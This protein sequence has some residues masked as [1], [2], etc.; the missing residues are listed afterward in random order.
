MTL[1]RRLLWML[2]IPLFLSSCEDKMSEHYD[3]KPE[4]FE[5]SIWEVLEKDGNYSSFLNAVKRV[6]YE[7]ML[8]GKALLTVMAP[9]DKAFEAYL[10]KHGA[11]SVNDMDVEEL[12]KMVTFHLLYY[13]YEK[14]DLENFRIN[15]DLESEDQ[16]VANR[17]L[18]Y[19]FRTKSADAPTTEYDPIT[20]KKVTVYHFERFMP[21][22]SHYF[23]Q[24]RALDAK[25]SY[26]YFY[27]NSTWTGDDGFNV[28]DATVTQYEVEA[29]NGYIYKVDRVIEPLETIYTEMKNDKNYSQFVSLY[30]RFR[31]YTYDATIS[32]DYAASAGVDSLFLTSYG[33]LANLAQEWST[34]SYMQLSLL[35][36]NGYSLFAPSNTALDAFFKSF[37]GG[38]GYES[39]SDIDPLI[40]RYFLQSCIYRNQPV[41]PQDIT[42]GKLVDDFGYGVNFD[43]YNVKNRKVC[44]NG[45][46]YGLDQIT[47]PPLFTTVTGP[48]FAQKNLRAFAYAITGSGLSTSLMSKDVKYLFL[49]ANNDQMLADNMQVIEYAKSDP[50]LCTNET[51]D[52]SWGAV[53]SETKQNLANIHVASGESLNASGTQVVATQ[54]AFNYWFVDNGKITT[55]A[56]F[57]SAIANSATNPFSAFHEIS[58]NDIIGG[59]WVNG[60]VYSYDDE[61][62]YQVSAVENAN[63]LEASIATCASGSYPF[64]AFAQ[65]MQKSG[66]AD[67][68]NKLLFNLYPDAK[69]G[70]SIGDKVARFVLFAP[71]NEAVNA[72]LQA[73]KIPGASGSIVGENVNVTITDQAALMKYLKT[74]FILSD[75]NTISVYPYPGSAFRSDIVYETDGEGKLV[76]SDNGT[77]LRVKL[78]GSSHEC[79]AVSVSKYTSFCFPYA[80]SDGCVQFI[81]S[82]IE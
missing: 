53:S 18:Y 59:P 77:T 72:A 27:P 54:A 1:A 68:A 23:F 9:D 8:Q 65:L 6:G 50:Q 4:L 79:T 3:P 44:V 71:T 13:S 7:K 80:Y 58:G 76:Y 34:T 28:A 24:S 14:K 55:S 64:Y 35:M 56:R 61:K 22:F 46:F 49:V 2:L 63:D 19:K 25:S 17:G 60:K 66:L 16:A 38:R 15:G 39:W 47:M 33:S 62:V 43:P 75:K 42:G 48:L 40:L 37:W 69:S 10:Q 74:F 36:T 52:G 21:V 26:E 30:D 78:E 57:N 67:V 31:T 70:G 82:V 32:R 51:D 29:D 73:G 5:G 20:E 81:D 11:S 45:V 41:F 12:K